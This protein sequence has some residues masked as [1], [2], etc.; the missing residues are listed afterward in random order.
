MSQL[1]A[2]IELEQFCREHGFQFHAHGRGK[3]G[4][5]RYWSYY[6]VEDNYRTVFSIEYFPFAHRIKIC[7]GANR[8]EGQVESL[9]HFKELLAVM[10]INENEVVGVTQSL[11]PDKTV[12]TVTKKR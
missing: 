6:R 7:I 8:Y 3:W 4:S 10:R 9:P 12:V 2:I 11:K 1:P 5:G